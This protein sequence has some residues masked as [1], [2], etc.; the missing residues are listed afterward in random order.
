MSFI[1]CK[2]K[3]FN[4]PLYVTNQPKLKKD[5]IEVSGNI[6]LAINLERNIAD[7]LRDDLLEHYRDVVIHP[8]PVL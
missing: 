8:E 2:H 5:R 1:S 7:N 6:K 3:K 4:T